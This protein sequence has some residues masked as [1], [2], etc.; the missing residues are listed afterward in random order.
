MPKTIK[1]QIIIFSSTDIRGIHKTS[2]EKQK[3]NWLWVLQKLSFDSY[4]H[5][6]LSYSKTPPGWY[7]C[8]VVYQ[9][10]QI[11]YHM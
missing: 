7:H 9:S 2:L 8:E 10:Y 3:E 4:S 1:V 6:L 5:K 11:V